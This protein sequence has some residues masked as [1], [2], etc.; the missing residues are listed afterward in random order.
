MARN[1]AR[2]QTAIHNDPTWRKLDWSAQH[3][4]WMLV[5]HPD[6]S[7]C[8]RIDYIP[9]RWLDFAGGLTEQ[10]IKTAV[11]QLERAR[12]VV[13]DRKTHE[14]LIRSFIRH[15]KILARR[16]IGNACGR[17]LGLVHSDAIREAVLHELARLYVED[18]SREGWA[19]FKDYD[20]EAFAMTCA[21]ASD[22][23]CATEEAIA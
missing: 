20:P 5:T 10:K 16:N 11:R 1:H 14:L 21:M 12:Y 8:G 15:D 23:T 17:A 6:V 22:M 7:Y 13:V 2:I 18:S 19:G 4:Y 3:V 9:G